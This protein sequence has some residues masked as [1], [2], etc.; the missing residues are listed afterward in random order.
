MDRAATLLALWCCQ[1][2]FIITSFY[3]GD[4]IWYV[5]DVRKF[6]QHYPN[7]HFEY[8]MRRTVKEMIEAALRK[9]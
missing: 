7:W 9:N 2:V 1:T 5:S 4:Y 3:S 8:D 6:Q